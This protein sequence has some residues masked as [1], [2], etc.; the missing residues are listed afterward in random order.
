MRYKVLF[1]F[2][3]LLLPLALAEELSMDII[4][5]KQVY[6]AGENVSF[7]VILLQN[8]NPISNPIT[9]KFSDVTDKKVI[10]KEVTPNINQEFIIEK[11]YLSGY[12]KIEASYNN[13][14]V[15]RF[16]TI[17]EREEA[18][19]IIE[20]EKL[21]ITNTG[22]VPYTKTLQI[23]IGEKV[24]SQKQFIDIGESKEI[25]LVAPEGDYN[26]QVSDG[27]T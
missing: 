20:G 19:F 1:F 11:A 2:L 9:V 10:T 6:S 24:I 3:V 8:N 23:L 26:V 27:K 5:D 4:I 15:K 12:W 21:I 13:Q 25:R 7:K 17:G 16:F 18:E 22:N 14:T